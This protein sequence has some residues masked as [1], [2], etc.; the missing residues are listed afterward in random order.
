MKSITLGK[1]ET[2]LDQFEI[3]VSYPKF[4]WGYND[5]CLCSPYGYEKSDILRSCSEEYYKYD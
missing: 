2:S 5:F 3:N 1:S 4:E